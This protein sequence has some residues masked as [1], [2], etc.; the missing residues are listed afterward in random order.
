MPCKDA[1]KTFL[2]DVLQTRLEDVLR[3]LGRRKMVTL[4]TSWETRNVCC[5]IT[6]QEF[7]KLTSKN[8]DARLKLANLASKNDIAD[9][10]KGADFDDKLKKL[11]KNVA[12][13]KTKHVIVQNELYKLSEKFKLT[14]TKGLAK[15]LINNY[16][17]AN[18]GKYFGEKGLRN[19]LVSQEFS[20]Y[21]T[22]KNGKIG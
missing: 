5:D 11:F 19:Y 16:I 4:K 14:S 8:F 21:L 9:F 13:K 10:V 7:N 15:S 12:L 2:E 1:L 6:N 22:S 20:R 3:R 18:S 17:I